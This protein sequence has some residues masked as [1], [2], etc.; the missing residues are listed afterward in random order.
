MCFLVVGLYSYTRFDHLLTH[1]QLIVAISSEKSAFSSRDEIEMTSNGIKI[2][3]GVID[4]W[5]AEVYQDE[6]I[7]E[8]LVTLEMYKNLQVLSS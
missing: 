2:A 6:T 5:T 1:D 8:W 4:Y 3:F 7:I